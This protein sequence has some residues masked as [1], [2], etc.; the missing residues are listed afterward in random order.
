M[1]TSRYEHLEPKV[2][3]MPEIHV[4]LYMG[5]DVEEHVFYCIRD[6]RRFV[7]DRCTMGTVFDR[8]YTVGA[9]TLEI[10]ERYRL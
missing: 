4:S 2:P 9:T 10:N 3:C 5:E 8:S 1:S 6:Y 7:L